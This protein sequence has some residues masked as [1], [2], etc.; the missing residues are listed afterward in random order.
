M[1]EKRP[2]PAIGSLIAKYDLRREKPYPQYEVFHQPNSWYAHGATLKNYCGY[3]QNKP[4]GF[5]IQHG[6]SS[7]FIYSDISVIERN[8]VLPLIGIASNIRIP[9]TENQTNKL[10]F[11]LGP[12][13][14][15]ASSALNRRHSGLLGKI[16]DRI[17]VVF[18]THSTTG[19]EVGFDVWKLIFKIESYRSNFDVVIFCIYWTDLLA[20][21]NWI[22]ILAE[23]GEIVTAGHPWDPSFQNNLRAIIED[24]DVVASTDLGTALGYANQLE[25]PIWFM[26]LKVDY[27]FLSSVEKDDA[28]NGA[29]TYRSWVAMA[30]YFGWLDFPIARNLN[31]IDVIETRNKKISENDLFD[32]MELSEE[33]VQLGYFSSPDLKDRLRELVNDK[34][35]I[36]NKSRIILLSLIEKS[37]NSRAELHEFSMKYKSM[38]I[39]DPTVGG[40]SEVIPAVM[41]QNNLRID[42]CCG[43][44]KPEGFIGVDR[45]PGK[46]VDIVHDLNH[47]FPFQDSVAA[48][49]RGYYA[50]EH[51]RDSLRTMNEI[52]R[53]CQ[54]DAIVELMVPST[55]GR[56]AFQDPAHVSFWNENSFAYYTIDNPAYLL[57]SKGYGFQG[58]FRMLEMKSID[59]G[60]KVI[61]IF[62]KMQAVK[63]QQEIN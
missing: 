58:E 7:P 61:Q 41:K 12:I 59:C 5:V 18:P 6:W 57:H 24:A 43:E 49:V 46:L 53:I 60:N 13:N 14:S 15:Y 30:E 1:T 9:F 42:L 47:S 63:N 55:D 35:K 22:S 33:L 44:R 17:L 32:I 23:Y 37:E 27:K 28:T 8:S 39:F 19:T 50:I 20:E 45:Y 52:W 21:S 3:P 56:G 36:S 16:S 62:V 48:Y 25:I 38:L 26:Q 2:H 11:E 4:L 54:H 29:L 31:S 34:Q 51:L 40:P 10:S